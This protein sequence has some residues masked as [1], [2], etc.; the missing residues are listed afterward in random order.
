MG[1]LSEI[2]NFVKKF[3]K[4]PITSMAVAYLIYRILRKNSE[5]SCML[6]SIKV[7]SKDNDCEIIFDTTTNS[8]AVI[9]GRGVHNDIIPAKDLQHAKKIVQQIKNK[10][11]SYSNKERLNNLYESFSLQQ[12]KLTVQKLSDKWG[13]CKSNS[14]MLK[15]SSPNGRIKQVVRALNID[16]IDGHYYF[17]VGNYVVDNVIKNQ[18]SAY[19][20]LKSAEISES[21][22]DKAKYDNILGLKEKF[23]R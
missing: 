23:M 6:E 16:G 10:K 12:L 5:E 4:S 20:M 19:K 17:E 8:Y 21:I 13:D 9:D 11:N 18:T 1:L 3:V 7:I 2:R 15:C 14:Y 22:F